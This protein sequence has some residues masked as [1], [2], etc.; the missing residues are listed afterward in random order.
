MRMRHRTN[1][2]D[3]QAIVERV[4]PSRGLTPRQTRYLIYRQ[5]LW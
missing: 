2:K 4:I 5:I 1:L 3:T